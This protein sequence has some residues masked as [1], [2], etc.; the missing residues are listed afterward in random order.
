MKKFALLISLIIML[1]S[2]TSCVK[3]PDMDGILDSVLG[4][5][6]LQEQVAESIGQYE[7]KEI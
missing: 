3:P 6:T 5:Q 2:F 4:T 7:N 1:L